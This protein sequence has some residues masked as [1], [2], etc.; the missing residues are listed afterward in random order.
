MCAVQ[1]ALRGKKRLFVCGLALDFCVMDT[2]APPAPLSSSLAPRLA[3]IRGVAIVAATAAA[4]KP[5]AART[6]HVF[7][8]CLNAKDAGFDSVHMVL[9][10]ARAAHVPG[11]GQYGS[12]FLSDPKA[13]LAKLTEAKVKLVSTGALVGPPR[14]HWGKVASVTALSVRPGSKV[15]I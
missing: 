15:A 2:W 14:S 11:I 9:D 6:P 1:D 3:A 13:V 8:R 5:E 12:G 7:R 4:R 10:A